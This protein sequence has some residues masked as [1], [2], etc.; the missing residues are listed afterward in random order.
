MT[1]IKW[2]IWSTRAPTVWGCFSRAVL[3]LCWAC[4]LI[5]DSIRSFMPSHISCFVCQTIRRSCACKHT[6]HGRLNTWGKANKHAHDPLSWQ[7]I[8]LHKSLTLEVVCSK[9]NWS[10]F[11]RLSTYMTD[12]HFIAKSQHETTQQAF[13]CNS[14]ELSLWSGFVMSMKKSLCE[15]RHL[16]DDRT[17]TLF[18]TRTDKFPDCC[19]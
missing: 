2:D 16:E 1:C 7:V 14:A 9:K 15:H 18:Q 12:G 5:I 19:T 6:T 3:K 11:Y 13:I 10:E 4:V 8:V 17:E